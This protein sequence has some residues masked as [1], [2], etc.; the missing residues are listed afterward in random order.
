MIKGFQCSLKAALRSCLAGSDWFLHLPLVLLG[1]RTV[2]KDDSG[3]SVF[4]AF[5]GSPLTVPGEF[6]GSRE[7]P[8]RSFCRKIKNTV[9][10]FAIPPPHHVRPS[11]PHQL[12]PA[13]LVAYFV[14][15]CEEASVSSLGPQY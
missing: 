11:L 5:Y 3:L 6:L 1:L 7:L 10:G 2:P 15:V 8:L 4:E 13:L 9:A 12:P 14:F